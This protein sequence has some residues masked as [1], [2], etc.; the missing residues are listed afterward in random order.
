MF[1][2]FAS[3]SGMTSSQLYHVIREG[4]NLLESIDLKVLAIVADGALTNRKFFKL[5]HWEKKENPSL[6]NVTVVKSLHIFGVRIN[7]GNANHQNKFIAPD[8]I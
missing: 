6:E 5:H 1:G 2:H 4:V 7:C 3:S 8:P